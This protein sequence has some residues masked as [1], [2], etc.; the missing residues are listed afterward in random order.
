MQNMSSESIF[1]ARR[2]ENKAKILQDF[3]PVLSEDIF[4]IIAPFPF[5]NKKYIVVKSHSILQYATYG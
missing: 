2:R 1:G 3:T 4:C 5:G